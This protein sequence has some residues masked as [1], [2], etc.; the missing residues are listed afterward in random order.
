MLDPVPGV[1][2]RSGRVLRTLYPGSIRETS[3]RHLAKPGS[4]EQRSS[5]EVYRPSTNF[6]T[7]VRLL[8]IVVGL[9]NLLLLLL[10]PLL[11]LLLQHKA[12]EDPL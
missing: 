9:S 5:D 10:L 7:P 12:D 6:Q 4:D 2:L 3:L 1:A 11:L 8:P